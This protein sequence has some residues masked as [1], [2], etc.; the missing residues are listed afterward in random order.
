MALP[1]ETIWAAK[2][3]QAL[4]EFQ[5]QKGI[6]MGERAMVPNSCMFMTLHMSKDKNLY[7]LPQW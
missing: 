2:A 6:G 4:P 3:L 5:P 1:Q 7:S